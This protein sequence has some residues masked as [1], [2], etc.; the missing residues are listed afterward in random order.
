LKVETDMN[1]K[2]SEMWPWHEP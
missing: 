2:L 1:C